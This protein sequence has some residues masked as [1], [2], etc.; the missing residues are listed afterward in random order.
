MKPVL[1]FIFSYFHDVVNFGWFCDF[2]SFL[3]AAYPICG[4]LKYHSVSLIASFLIIFLCLIASD[5]SQYLF[6]YVWMF[7]CVCVGGRV[8]CVCTCTWRLEVKRAGCC[9]FS[10]MCMCARECLHVCRY[11]V[12]ASMPWHV[13]VCLWRLQLM[14]CVFHHGSPLYLWRQRLFLHLE[15]SASNCPCWLPVPAFEC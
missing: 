8:T 14:S 13:C 2:T 9:L 6:L 5:L 15:F 3:R 4:T 10:V 1:D 12:C 7:T 11:P